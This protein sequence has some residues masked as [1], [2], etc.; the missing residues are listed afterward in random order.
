MPVTK[1]NNKYSVR[2]KKVHRNPINKKI[3]PGY[4]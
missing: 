1:L 3:I 2:N 4:P